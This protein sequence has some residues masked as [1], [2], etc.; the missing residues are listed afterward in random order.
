[1]K[2]EKLVLQTGRIA[3]I[4][5]NRPEKLNALDT[6]LKKELI[7]AIEEVKGDP[8]AK[9]L[10]FTGAGRSFCAGQDLSETVNKKAE[11]AKQ[12]IK[13]F[14]NLY[15][16]IRGID[17]PTIAAIRGHA[18]GAGLQIALLP[19]I[20][21]AA[22]DAKLGLPEIDVGLPCITGSGILHMLGTPLC[23]IAELIMTGSF[24]SGKEAEEMGLVNKAVPSKELDDFVLKMAENIASRPSVAER[25]NKGWLRELTAKML[26]EA[27]DYAVKAHTQGFASGEPAKGMSNFLTKSG[28]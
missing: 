8:T 24:M 28:N 22:D 26:Q 14:D 4:T 6:Q 21:I 5:L 2:F 12:W 3:K 9:V 18:V 15:S 20:K 11:D 16:A 13:G 23:K 1:M 19:D 7:S 17:I 27:M 10:I 25:L